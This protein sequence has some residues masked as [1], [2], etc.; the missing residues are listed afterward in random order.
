[1]PEAPLQRA[2]SFHL[3]L[4]FFIDHRSLPFP[5]YSHISLL[6][7]AILPLPSSHFLSSSLPRSPLPIFILNSLLLLFLLHHFLLFPLSVSTL[8]HT[9]F[10][11]LPSPFT[12]PHHLSPP[13]LFHRLPH[14][15]HCSSSLLFAYLLSLAIASLGSPHPPL[16]HKPRSGLAVG[17]GERW[18]SSLKRREKDNWQSLFLRSCASR[19]RERAHVST[20]VRNEPN[21]IRN[22]IEMKRS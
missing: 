10:L 5:S 15:S 12:F 16:Y 11:I 18:N 17:E 2:V 13:L 1:M 19:Q 6:S 21:R 22:E 8:Q 20:H 3:G 7:E 4:F 14:L 9:H